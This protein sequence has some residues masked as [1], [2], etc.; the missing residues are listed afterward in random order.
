MTARTPRSSSPRTLVALAAAVVLSLTSASASTAAAPQA[1]APAAERLTGT[2]PDGAAWIADVPENWNGTL[3]VF[4]HGFGVTV[5]QNAPREA[6]RL[7][8]L[9]EGYALTGSSYDVSETLWALESAERDQVA[10]IAAVTERI[11]EPTRTLSVGQSMGGLVNARLARSGA[12][13]IDGALGLC[14]L[15]AGANDLHTYQLDAEY[16]IARLLLPGTPV[17]LVDFASEAEG[18]A[19]GR[20]LTDAVVA[21]QKTPEG[22]ARIA[23]AAAYLNLP[24]WSPGKDR[25]GAGDWAEQQAQQYEWLAQGILT[26]VEPARYHVE[27]ALGGNNSGNK[28]VDYARVL[29]TSQHAPLVKALYK[30]AGLD[31]RADLRNLTANAT[32]TADPAAVAA[33]ERTSSAGQGLAVP[34]L[35]V[36]TVA[37]D[38]VPVEQESRFATRVRASGDAPLLRQA[39][40]ERQGHCTFTTAETV[41]ALHALESRLDSGRWGVS[42]T[43]GALQ[44][45][46]LALGLDGA[47]YVPYRPAE[48]TIGRRP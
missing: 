7:R 16:T 24:A 22:R 32:V 43:P 21:A 10:T 6:V 48:L 40:V 36:H 15:V 29:S 44:T 9:E 17:K 25:P 4:S 23:L 8:L 30:K 34:L 41:A 14:G 26:R 46:A 38:L 13:G 42:A 31:L 39:Y 18:A 27:K 3:V 47:A 11:G 1:A 19:T 5:P 20:Q 33:G 35:D 12:G 28:G 2:L 37:D 45:A